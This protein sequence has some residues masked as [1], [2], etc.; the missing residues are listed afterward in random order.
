MHVFIF[1]FV[2]TCDPCYTLQNRIMARFVVVQN[3]PQTH[4][5]RLSVRFFFFVFFLIFF[6]ITNKKKG[7]EY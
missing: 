2:L 3:G 5:I 7:V 6:K 1:I 4:R